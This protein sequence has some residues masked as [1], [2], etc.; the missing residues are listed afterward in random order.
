MK[1]R[2]NFFTSPF[3]LLAFLF[4]FLIA[5][6]FF[7]IITATPAYAVG[8]GENGLGTCATEGRV[9]AYDASNHIYKYCNGT[10]WVSIA[11]TTG[12]TCTTERQF[13]RTGSTLN[14]CNGT[15]WIDVANGGTLT[16]CTTI[17]QMDYD[18]TAHLF[19]WCNGANWISMAGP[20]TPDTMCVFATSTTYTGSIGSVAAADTDCSTR[21]TAAALPGIFKA[22]IG[23]NQSVDDPITTFIHTTDAYKLVDGTTVFNNWTGLETLNPLAGISKD[24]NGTA[25]ASSNAWTNLYGSPTGWVGLAYGNGSSTVYNCSAWTSANSGRTALTGVVG[26]TDS[27]WTQNVSTTACNTTNHLYCFQQPCNQPS[28]VFTDVRNAPRSTLITSNIAAAPYSAL[29]NNAVT[30]SG[31]GSPKFRICADATC[32]TNPAYGTTGTITGA[33]QYVQLELTSAPNYATVYTADLTIGR[34]T[35]GWTVQTQGE[36]IFISSG[37]Y[38]GNFSTGGLDNGVVNAGADCGAIASGAG[39]SGTWMAWMAETTGVDDPG[40]LMTEST[41]PYMDITATTV[42]ANNWAGLTSGTLL[43]GISKDQT[44][45]AVTAGSPV[46]TDAASNGTASTSGPSSTAN[47]SSGTSRGWLTNSGSPNKGDYGLTGSTTSTWTASSNQTCS[48]ASHIYCVEQAPF[49]HPFL[50]ALYALPGTLATSNIVNVSGA[51]TISVS[52]AGSPQFRIC[53]D[54]WCGTVV[55]TWGAATQTVSSL[56]QTYVQLENT[57]SAT[58]GTT[59]TATLAADEDS[60]PWNLTAEANMRLVLPMA[61]AQLSVQGFFG[62]TGNLGIAGANLTCTNWAQ[63]Y[64]IGGS[65]KAW[66][67]VTA[68]VDDPATTFTQSTGPYVLADTATGATGGTGTAIIANNW[69]GLI[70]GTL[71]NPMASSCVANSYMYTNVAT[72]GTATASGVGDVNCQ[73]YHSNFGTANYGYA[74]HTDSTW[75]AGGT[76][77][78]CADSPGIVG[79]GIYCFQQTLTPV[80]AFFDKYA[81]PGTLVTSDIV[82]V[83]PSAAWT[84]AI[85]GTGSPKFRVCSQSQCAVVVNTWGTANQTVAAG[86]YVQLENTSSA[87]D[88]TTVTATLTINS[89]ASNWKVTTDAN[90]KLVFVTAAA[91]ATNGNVAGTSFNSPAAAD[92]R[93]GER[94]TA[95]GLPGTYKAWIATTTGVDD[96][97]TRFTHATGRYLL[98]DGQTVIANNWAG[99]ISG[100]LLNPPTLRDDGYNVGVFP[101]TNVATNGTATVS[102]SS[103][104]ANC[105][106]WTN[107]TSGTAAYGFTGYLTSFWTAD[108]TNA[109]CTSTNN[110]LCFQQ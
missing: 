45:T 61:D 55:Q 40:T 48:T 75:T 33:G 70:S 74:C 38:Q 98:I 73:N 7:S 60:I 30:I 89:L 79:F 87:T 110:L 80:P 19:K 37:T 23:I 50:T 24:E 36:R 44:G 15:N 95:A 90:E 53:S 62:N 4:C 12:A 102:G 27:T 103:T 58:S 41:V 8:C 86:N 107:N 5:G 97:A 21:A 47:C 106:A 43:A 51:S 78:G 29:C 66:P 6:P 2:R 18:Y 65:W 109:A 39:L 3:R 20:V 22:W 84:V 46:W 69:A 31:Q 101:W 63:G 14:F 42:I 28:P 13:T 93:C 52:G 99:L 49:A 85:S 57:S 67:A 71:L 25:V 35:A 17:G 11:G 26:A 104:T 68:G 77:G 81:L 54:N 64:G 76:Y 92:T 105:S 88:G 108:G 91:Y 83:D 100:T 82:M 32:S 34:V 16:S 56:A 96:P 10:V 1:T 9:F 94:A 72:N 59:L